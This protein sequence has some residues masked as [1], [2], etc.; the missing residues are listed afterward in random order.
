M[1]K[2]QAMVKEGGVRA[3]VIGGDNPPPVEI[4]FTE[5]PNIGRASVIAWLVFKSG[6]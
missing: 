2:Y 3:V 4:G 1:L 6:F 5:L